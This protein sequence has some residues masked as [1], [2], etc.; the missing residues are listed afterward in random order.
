MGVQWDSK[1]IV[2]FLKK[3]EKEWANI[4]ASVWPGEVKE[5]LYKLLIL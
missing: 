3:V 1:G 4:P 2:K 5:W